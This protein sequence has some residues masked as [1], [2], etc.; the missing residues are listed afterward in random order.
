MFTLSTPPSVLLDFIKTH[1]HF[2]VA[3]HKEP[4]GDCVGSQ[5]ALVS[6]LRRLHK[7]AIACSAGP[8]KRPEITSFSSFFCSDIAA[9]KQ[10][11]SVCIIVDCGASD[12]TGDLEKELSA[13]PMAIIDHHETKKMQ[14]PV[15]YLDASAPSTTLLV[16]SLIKALCGNVTPQEAQFLFFGFCTDTGFFRHL[17]GGS[18]GALAAAAELVAAGANPKETFIT[19]SGGKSLNSRYLLGKIL[20]RAQPYFN[21]KLLLS[22]EELAETE[23]FGLEGRDS[24]SLYQLLSSV[25]GV[26]AIA[27]I[28]QESPENCTVGLRSRD[29]VDVAEIAGS[30]GGGG[31]KNAAGFMIPGTISKVQEQLLA[32]FQPIFKEH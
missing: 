23:S 3:G 6:A 15:Q 19:M 9:L 4:D 17:D 30:F 31:H 5:L 26:E 16:F 12:R 8:F 18:A 7:D 27:I 21:G 11:D 22:S 13:L 14:C 25:A 2:F 20:S 10:K 29:S 1:T 28:R 32:V 24:D